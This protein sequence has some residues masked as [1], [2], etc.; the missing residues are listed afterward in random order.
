MYEL[1]RENLKYIQEHYHNVGVVY[2]LEYNGKRYV[3]STR[4]LKRRI[5]EYSNVARLQRELLKGESKI[6][7]AILKHGLANFTLTI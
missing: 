7:R 4:N 2:V 3:G 6:H 5:T 1:N